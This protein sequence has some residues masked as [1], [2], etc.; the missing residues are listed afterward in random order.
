MKYFLLIFLGLSLTFSRS[1]AQT[2]FIHSQD[3]EAIK[4]Q[5]KKQHK[6]IFLDAY[7]DWCGWCKVMDKE[8]FSDPAIGKMMNAYFINCKLELEQDETGKQIALK[9]GVS[10]F[11]SFLVFNADGDLIYTSMGFQK[12]QD[13]MNT[14]ME[15]IFP[16]KQEKRPGY[17]ALFNHEY[18]D[19]YLKAMGMKG[20]KKF[21]EAKEVNAWFAKNSELQKEENWVVYQRFQYLLNAKNRNLFWEN[22]ALLD[23]FY[24]KDQTIRVVQSLLY[25]EVK[26]L[27]PKNNPD[28]LKKLFALRSTLVDSAEMNEAG[29]RIYYYKETKNWRMLDQSLSRTFAAKGAEDAAWWNEQCWDIYEQSTDSTLIAHA[30]VW[31]QAACE[32]DDNYNHLDTYASILYKAGHLEAAE[33]KIKE[34][35]TKGRAENLK[36]ESS[37]ELLKK[38][39]KEQKRLLEPADGKN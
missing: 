30:T 5:A 21:P 24:G 3:W 6:L 22:K 1:D 20:K 23:S 37:E 9:Y 36:I 28:E 25:S 15:I 29:L 11:P 27:V 26:E 33:I 16:G 31:M 14:L 7:T 17:D 39:Q 2:P 35:I 8:T 34:A 18:P 19:F 4:T 38:I 10:A 12:P 32:V 13:F